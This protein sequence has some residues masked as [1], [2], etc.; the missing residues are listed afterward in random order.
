MYH[1]VNMTYEEKV[2]MYDTMEKYQLIEMLI[3]ANENIDRITP[4]ICTGFVSLE[5]SH[6]T[7]KCGKHK[8]DH[9]SN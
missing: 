3:S 6:A 9:Y 5:G 8:W 1:T 2:K 7:C 4:K